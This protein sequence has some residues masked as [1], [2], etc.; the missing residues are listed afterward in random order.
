MSD[1]AKEIAEI[2]QRYNKEIAALTAQ[3]LKT[4]EGLKEK[5]ATN[6]AGAPKNT[7]RGLKEKI[8]TDGMSYF[9]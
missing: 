2:T 5:A 7:T 8:E 6:G 1:L 9:R 4:L 3:Y